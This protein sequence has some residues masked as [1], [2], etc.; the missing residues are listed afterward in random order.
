MYNGS[1]RS[2]RGT[3]DINWLVLPSSDP[4]TDVNGQMDNFDD[5]DGMCT[6]FIKR[7]FHMNLVLRLA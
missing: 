2:S 4:S 5:M 7:F 1:R 3:V 6:Y